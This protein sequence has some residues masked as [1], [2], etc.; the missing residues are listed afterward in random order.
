M[1]KATILDQNVYTARTISAFDVTS[2]KK[3]QTLTRRCVRDAASGLGL[4][5]LH[6][7]EGPFLHDAGQIMKEYFYFT[8]KAGLKWIHNDLAKIPQE[9]ENKWQM[10]TSSISVW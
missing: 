5:F 4:H 7:S 1:L 3:V 6:M 2:V 8:R 9:K 10:I